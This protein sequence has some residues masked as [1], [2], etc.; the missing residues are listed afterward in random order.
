MGFEL[1]LNLKKLVEKWDPRPEQGWEAQSGAESAIP[2]QI[3][4]IKISK[5][6]L[7]RLQA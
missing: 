6:I 5:V 7:E 3:E 2:L 4:N 1:F